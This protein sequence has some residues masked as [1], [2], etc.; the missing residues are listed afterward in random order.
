MALDTGAEW[1]LVGL[2]LLG[3]AARTS[4]TAVAAG[5]RVAAGSGVVVRTFLARVAPHQPFAFMSR[6]TV[7][8]ATSIP[9][10]CR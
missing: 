4:G 1:R 8:R 10:R 9:S 5:A 6:S 3:A 2:G 7:Q